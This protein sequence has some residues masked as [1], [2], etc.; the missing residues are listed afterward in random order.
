MRFDD[1]LE[2]VLSA[3]MSTPFGAQSAWRQLVDLIGRRRVPPGISAIAKLKAIRRH[4][5]PPIRAA[6]ARG[7]AFADPP[8]ALVQ[9]FAEDDPVIAAPVL[10]TARLRADEWIAMLSGMS[11]A[12][13]SILRHRRDLPPAVSRALEGFGSVDFVLSAGTAAAPDERRAGTPAAPVEVKIPPA[14]EIPGIE[15]GEAESADVESDAAEAGGVEV[16]EVETEE[17]E[18]GEVE[19]GAIGDEGYPPA[20]A[21]E[22]TIDWTDVLGPLPANEPESAILHVTAPKPEQAMPEPEVTESRTEEPRLVAQPRDVVVKPVVEARL[23]APPESTFVSFASVALGLPVVAEAFRQTGDAG[24]SIEPPQPAEAAESFEPAEIQESAEIPERVETSG[25]VEALASETCETVVPQRVASEQAGPAPV[26]EV[27]EIAK[28][29]PPPAEA[30]SGMFQIAELVARIDAWQRQRDESPAAPIQSEIQPELF[31]FESVQAQSFR[32]ETDASGVVR[33]IEGAAR[34]PLIGLSLDLAALPG[35]SRVDGAAAGAFRRRAGFANARLVVDGESDAA[36]HWRITG[37][38]VFDRESGRFTGYRGTAR[39]P[40]PDETAEP[41]PNRNPASDALRQLV[42]ELRTPTNAIAGFAEMIETQMLGPVPQVYRTY[43]TDIRNQAGSLLTAI[44][45]IDMAAR[46]DSKAL[47]LRPGEVSLVPLL[48]RIADDLAPLATLRG[49]VIDVYA[50]D[51]ELAIAG[52]DRAVERL[53]GRL[54]ATL[55]ASGGRDERIGIAA[56]LEADS[57]VAIVFDR[58]AALAAYGGDSLLTIDAETEA[59]RDGAPLL[60]T[61]FA[62]RLARNLAAELCGTL[63]IADKA[64]T[65]RLPAAVIDSVEQ[66]SSN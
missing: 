61:G 37:I 62:L 22:A 13:R 52:D 10:R 40:R 59:E 34:A 16:P 48:K 51:R 20:E 24:E 44:D 8:A 39:R 29:Q 23:I 14:V 17:V 42:H 25:P 1:S 4:V 9:L 54:M 66:V 55:V 56:T 64:L 46:I 53:I 30:A 15:A 65:L 7:L 47:D 28:L 58:P 2:T 49:T 43:A 31:E 36:G 32:F 12:A 45:D 19:T 33:W 50:G 63:V 6:S 35:G 5:P 3:D 18:T 26:A 57:V 38:P 41:R 27:I 21:K 11:P 60:G